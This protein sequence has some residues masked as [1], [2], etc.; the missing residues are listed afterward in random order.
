MPQIEPTYLRYINDELLKGKLNAENPA[1]LPDGFTGIYDEVFTAQMSVKEREK[2][3]QQLAV[4]AL[5]KKEVSAQFVA[6]VLETTEEE[7]QELVGRFS[8]WF[9]S[10][11]SGK[12]QLYHERLKVYL[13]E[14]LSASKNH[15][16][17]EK[18][19]LFLEQSLANQNEDE[20]EYYALEFMSEYL[21]VD[22]FQKKEKG[23]TL[24][25][26]VQN[27]NIWE[28]QI[29]IS[30]S[31]NWSRNGLIR[32]INVGIKDDH[33]SVVDLSLD[34]IELFDNQDN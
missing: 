32:G 27:K 1:G 28:R 14:K 5:L 7:V 23:K 8:S 6:E 3:L 11:E 26:F 21:M 4:W 20:A 13:L 29:E 15:E 24:F 25:D 22:A 10:P 16:I 30:N 12:Y 9:N 17:H 33:K 18:L 19:I 34:L 2:L 31:Y